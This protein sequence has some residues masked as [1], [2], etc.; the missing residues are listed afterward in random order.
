MSG[1]AKKV[2]RLGS[3]N[4]VAK[5]VGIIEV[6]VEV[7]HARCNLSAG[8]PTRAAGAPNSRRTSLIPRDFLVRVMHLVDADLSLKLVGLA[9][10][11]RIPAGR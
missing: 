11:R 9:P 1:N 3:L 8:R 5:P 6:A 2:A 4:H 7:R 10:S